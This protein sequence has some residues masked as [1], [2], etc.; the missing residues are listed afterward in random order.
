VFLPW[1]VGVVMGFVQ[2]LISSFN[3]LVL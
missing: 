3:V 1:M 2:P